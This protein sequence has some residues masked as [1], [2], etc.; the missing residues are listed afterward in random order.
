MKL[1]KQNDQ[2]SELRKWKEKKKKEPAEF[3]FRP[4]SFYKKSS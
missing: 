3:T 4:V 2:E 1:D